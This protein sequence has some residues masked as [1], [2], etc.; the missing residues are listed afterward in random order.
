MLDRMGSHLPWGP[1]NWLELGWQQ[2]D[3]AGRVIW[4]QASWAGPQV[5]QEG[6]GMKV[7]SEWVP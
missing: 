3:F 1:K 7:A 6:P 2:K 4:G 5:W